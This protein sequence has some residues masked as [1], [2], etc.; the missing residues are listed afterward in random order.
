VAGEI[1]A[2]PTSHLIGKEIARFPCVYWPAF[3]WAGDLP[4]PK[5]L[6]VH[7]WLLFDNER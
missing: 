7:G 3:L 4:L 2:R 5:R 6:Y 1:C